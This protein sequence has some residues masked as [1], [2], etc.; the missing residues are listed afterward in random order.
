LRSTC[1]RFLCDD[2]K[3]HR[4]LAPYMNNLSIFFK[5]LKGRFAQG[6]NHRHGR[7]G[8]LSAERF[9]S[10]LLERDR[11]VATVA[12]YTVLNPVRAAL[13]ADPKGVSLQFS[14]SFS[15]SSSR[16]FSV[17]KHHRP[18]EIGRTVT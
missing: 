8:V 10:L 6:Y 2:E 18:I 7:Y 5:E 4:L 9:K 13:C 17:F 11:A 15:S 1:P 3:A 14:Q 12:A 16:T